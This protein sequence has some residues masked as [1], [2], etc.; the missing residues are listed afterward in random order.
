LNK[1]AARDVQRTLEEAMGEA[2]VKLTA[3]HGKD[4]INQLRQNIKDMRVR[5][6]EVL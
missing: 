4:D 5:E 2:G 1:K 3:E 6:S